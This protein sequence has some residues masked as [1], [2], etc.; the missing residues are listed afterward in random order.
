MKRAIAAATL[1]ALAGCAPRFQSVPL[2]TGAET[3]KVFRKTDPPKECQELQPFS[4]RTGE[5]CGAFGTLGSYDATYNSFR[6]RVF[7]LGGNAALLESE[8]PSH[9]AYGCYVN[10][11]VMNG[12]AYRCN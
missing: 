9:P 12:V 7:A 11:W 6:N 3:V 2:M 5:G 1:I 4:V 10:E 8:T